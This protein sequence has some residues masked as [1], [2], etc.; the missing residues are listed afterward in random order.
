MVF[1]SGDI[2]GSRSPTLRQQS[3]LLLHRCIK[4]I[5]QISCP[6]T[7]HP[8]NVTMHSGIGDMRV[9]ECMGR[10]FIFLYL[11][12]CDRHSFLPAGVFS[13]SII[14]PGLVFSVPFV[15]VL[16]GVGKLAGGLGRGCKYYLPPGYG[17]E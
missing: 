1:V 15:V 12:R 9:V 13:W 17:Y 3:L 11:P 16:V 4:D 2:Q 6:N 7:K 14:F 5:L 10:L 8:V